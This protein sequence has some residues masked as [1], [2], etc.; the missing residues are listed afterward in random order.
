MSTCCFVDNYRQPIT[1]VYYYTKPIWYGFGTRFG[2]EAGMRYS[3]FCVQREGRAWRAR[4]KYKDELGRWRAKTKTLAGAVGKREA[5]RAAREWFDALNAEAEGAAEAAPVAAAQSVGEFM[6]EYVDGCSVH[7]EPST[8]NGYRYI[9]RQQVDP[10]PIAGIP[11]NALRPEKVRAW[12]AALT[13]RYGAATVSKAFVLLRSAMRQAVNDERLLR[14]PTDGVRPPKRKRPEPNAIRDEDRRRLAATLAGASQTPDVVGMT[15]ALY[16]GMREGEICALRWRNVDLGAGTIDV[17]ESIGKDGGRYYVKEPK[18]SGSRRTVAYP[19][20]VARALSARRAEMMEE[21][22][23]AG[24]S[25]SPDMFVLG[26]IDRDGTTGDFRF[27]H[28][29]TL[30]ERWRAFS[31][32]LA[33]IGT[34]GRRPT[35]HDLRHTYATTAIAAGVDVKTVSSQ[36][37]HANAAMTLNTYADADPDAKRRGADAVADAMAGGMARANVFMFRPNGT[38]G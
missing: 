31:D 3:S 14:N 6:A 32:L 2:T 38:E 21:A 19:A 20:P 22:I 12:L 9:L 11:V 7:A 33:L 26:R 17:R 25:F 36:L 10:Y 37:G 35:F 30:W 34:Q 29:R 16:T 1:T 5:E 4:A 18:T 24:V 28:P 15:L 13:E 23:R 27:L 8:V